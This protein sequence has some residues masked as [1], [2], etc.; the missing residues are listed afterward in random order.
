M[1]LWIWKLK[2]CALDFKQKNIIK[3]ISELPFHFNLL[4]PISQDKRYIVR[5]GTPVLVISFFV[6]CWLSVFHLYVAC[7]RLKVCFIDIRFFTKTHILDQLPSNP[8]ALIKSNILSTQSKVRT[9][10]YTKKIPLPQHAHTLALLLS[11]L[12]GCIQ[13]LNEY[14][15]PLIVVL[16]DW[17][18]VSW[19]FFLLNVICIDVDNYLCRNW[20]GGNKYS[21]RNN[22]IKMNYL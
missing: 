9:C 7:N 10:T 15:H 19:G 3:F 16:R 18:R 4:Q 11:N 20:H 21:Y 1:I 2:H 6:C 22:H 17:R 14:M 12:I 5:D 13:K 8:I